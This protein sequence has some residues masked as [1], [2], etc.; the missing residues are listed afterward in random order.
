MKPLPV[1]EAIL[2]EILES[3]YERLGLATVD[4]QTLPAG[5]AYWPDYCTDSPGYHGP[6]V[7]LVWH[8]SPGAMSSFILQDGRWV[9]CNTS[10]W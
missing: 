6:L 7:V 2:A 3:E 5:S 1:P 8:S 4:E 10:T 9:H